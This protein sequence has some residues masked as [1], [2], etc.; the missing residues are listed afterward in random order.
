MKI[1]LMSLLLLCVSTCMI[2]F[3]FYELKKEALAIRSSVTWL[4]LWLAIAVFSVFPDLMNWIINITQIKN[5]MFF[6]ITIAIIILFAFVFNLFSKVDR[7]QRKTDR[8]IQELSII[9][10]KLDRLNDK[11]S[12]KDDHDHSKNILS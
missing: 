11:K 2:M 1:T 6:A 9:S 4:V 10:Y 12:K 5:R 7:A 3:I 8:L